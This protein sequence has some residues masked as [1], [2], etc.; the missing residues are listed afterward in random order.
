MLNF[1]PILTKN[2]KEI[3]YDL[4]R[5]SVAINGAEQSQC[6]QR[7]VRQ[8]QGSPSNPARSLSQLTGEPAIFAQLHMW[9]TWLLSIEPAVEKPSN[10]P[11]IP[12]R[13]IPT[14]L[15]TL[16]KEMDETVFR[17]IVYCTLTGIKV[18][19]EDDEVLDCFRQIL[20]MSFSLPTTGEVCRLRKNQD[21]WS[22]EWSGS[23]P[24][25]LPKL[26][27][28]IEEGFKNENIPDKALQPHLTGAIMHW[29]N[30]ARSLSQVSNPN[31]QLLHAFGVQKFDL[32]MLAY[33]T[34]QCRKQ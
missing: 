31:Q 10:A 11:Q 29:L 4:Q 19:S 7:V 17:T 20:P 34:A 15:R 18:E 5:K 8:A 9:F 28:L 23:V 1:W 12:I 33:W 32:P 2:I 30:I 21:T 16:C 27:T 22:V 14:A 13:C 26:L 25:K 6:P 3:A 24:L